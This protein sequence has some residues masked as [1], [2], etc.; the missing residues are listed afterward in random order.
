[1][2]R[3]TVNAGFYTLAR[4][5][6]RLSGDGHQMSSLRQILDDHGPILL[7][8]A[9]SARVQT[10]WLKSGGEMRW[11]TS[12]EEAGVGIFKC[13]EG[14]G[15]RP[16][17]AGAFVYCDGPGSLLGIRTA[18][19]AIRAWHVLN[20]QPTFSYHS[21][22]VV[23]HA[24]G[25]PALNVIADARRDMWHC[26]SLGSPLRRVPTAELAGELAMPVGFRNWTALPPSVARVPY[27]LAEL[28]PRIMDV[29]L[30][31]ATDAPDAFLYE[32]PRYATW[33]PHIHRAP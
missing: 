6:T 10:G 13:I 24:L 20:A 17:H 15:I 31:R 2:G 30:M 32:E 12:E 23:A 11:A 25:R 21:L 7:L 19:M 33:T 22:E 8:D 18:A 5:G 14:L 3:E 9:C 26:I 16:N 28:F 4:G 29:D 1:M 27:S